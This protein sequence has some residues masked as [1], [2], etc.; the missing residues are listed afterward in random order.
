MCNGAIRASENADAAPD[1]SA[2]GGGV[3]RS[4]GLW[5]LAVAIL[6]VFLARRDPLRLLEEADQLRFVAGPATLV[7]MGALTLLL[8]AAPR[9]LR[10]GTA[11]ISCAMTVAIAINVALFPRVDP[12]ADGS[13][14]TP[15]QTRGLAELGRRKGWFNHWTIGPLYTHL[16]DY[17]PRATIVAYPNDKPT[18]LDYTTL[19]HPYMLKYVAEAAYRVED[20]AYVLTGEQ[21]EYLRRRPHTVL[22]DEYFTGLRWVVPAGRQAAGETFYVLKGATEHY[23]VPAAWLAEVRAP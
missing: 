18:Y 9:A 4:L 15:C 13:S 17:A 8:L 16:H 14:F 2:C 20:Y 6:G 12:S 22:S 5:G 3:W 21:E 19:V 1:G 7:A 10:R 23:L 11:L